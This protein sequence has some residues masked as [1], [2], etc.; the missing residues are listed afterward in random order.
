MIESFFVLFKMSFCDAVSIS[1]D[2]RICM[3]EY[4]SEYSSTR[5][6]CLTLSFNF[7]C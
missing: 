5:L 4:L 1:E 7:Y 3:S 6:D 2:E